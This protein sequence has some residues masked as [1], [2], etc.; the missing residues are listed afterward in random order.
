MYLIQVLRLVMFLTED[1]LRRDDIIVILKKAGDILKTPITL[2]VVGGIISVLKF[3]NREMTHDIDC[4]QLIGEGNLNDIMDKLNSE[5]NIS[6][7][8]FFNSAAKGFGKYNPVEPD[9]LFEHN[10][11]KLVPGS[12]YVQIINKLK[13]LGKTDTEDIQVILNYLHNEKLISQ[14]IIKQNLL[15]YIED[16]Y[17]DKCDII[18]RINNLDF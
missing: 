4:V 18:Q 13:R 17:Y 3:G 2:V 8:K 11:L 7:S 5:L 6:I 16:D 10:N 14:E 12:W 15:S 1:K 9:I